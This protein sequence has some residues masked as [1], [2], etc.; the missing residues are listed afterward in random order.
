MKDVSMWNE[1]QL[2]TADG[3]YRITFKA[4]ARRHFSAEW[5]SPEVEP[6]GTAAFSFDGNPGDPPAVMD[7]AAKDNAFSWNTRV[8]RIEL[9]V[10]GLPEGGAFRL[11]CQ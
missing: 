5:D 7:F 3:T 6:A 4:A 8:S 9:E 1:N 2:F 11:Y 10:A